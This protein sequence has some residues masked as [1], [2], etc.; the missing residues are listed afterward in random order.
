MSSLPFSIGDIVEINEECISD[1][2]T[3][4]DLLGQTGRVETMGINWVKISIGE[5]PQRFI[6]SADKLRRVKDEDAH[7]F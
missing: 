3:L 6:I 7:R 4:A 2:R 1:D 5:R